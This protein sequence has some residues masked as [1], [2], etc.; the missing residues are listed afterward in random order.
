MIIGALVGAYMGAAQANNSWDPAKWAWAD[1]KTWIG[2]FAGAA[3]GAFAVSGGVAS[4]GYFASMFG[5]SMLAAGLATGAISVAG[6]FLG[7]AAAANEW[8]PAKWDWSSPAVW[9]G[10][11]TGIS[12]GV[13]FP[14]GFVGITRTFMSFTMNTW[15]VVYAASMASGF[16]LLLYVGASMANNFNFRLD[17][18]DWKSPRTW[19]G[20]LEGVST[21]FMGTSAGVRHGAIR[22]HYI[23][24]PSKMKLAWYNIN[25][26]A[27]SF[28]VK[29]IG[30]QYVLTWYKY[31]N[32]MGIQYIKSQASLLKYIKPVVGFTDAFFI[33]HFQRFKSVLAMGLFGGLHYINFKSYFEHEPNATETTEATEKPQRRRR[34]AGSV[35]SAAGGPWGF[36]NDW[37]NAA[38]GNI[39]NESDQMSSTKSFKGIRPF[40]PSTKPKLD[41]RSYEKFC[42]SPN[43]TNDHVICPQW[44]ST[45]KVFF[46]HQDFDEDTFGK[47]TFTRCSP[48]YW[49]DQPSV[50]CEGQQS[51]FVYT[52]RQTTRVFD[53]VDGWLLLARVTPAAVRNLK[54]G[55]SFLRNALFGTE[56]CCPKVQRFAEQK[57]ELSKELK[58]IKTLMDN[59]KTDPSWA[60]VIFADLEDDIVEFG[61]KTNPTKSELT[62]LQERLDSLREDLME[63]ECQTSFSPDLNTLLEQLTNQ[64]HRQQ[65]GLGGLVK[66]MYSSN[67]PES[68]KNYPLLS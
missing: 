59:S 5:G 63:T 4:F 58:T 39:W 46:K 9:N 57:L 42:Y 22:T 51:T 62:L 49:H 35:T 38:V 68:N 36:L 6:A 7:A 12:I 45:V 18:W 44:D 10:F 52:P 14:S 61:A 24:Q 1:K 25:I 30:S 26:P 34:S 17:T 20:M 66:V 56:D 2:M 23:V 21:L 11:L 13:S 41:A 40:D 31:G 47:D 15:K 3:M 65:S 32:R 8:D 19:F 64:I 67:I 27:R 37:I 43:E 29:Q 16:L 50:T 48:M 28:T 33:S 53:M 60:N 54:S 55:F